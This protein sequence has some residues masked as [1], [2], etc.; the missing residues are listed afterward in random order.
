MLEIFKR[1]AWVGV[2]IDGCWAVGVLALLL[3]PFES[4]PDC[5]LPS[6]PDSPFGPS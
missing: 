1:V 3:V 2:G 5:D 6:S 4:V